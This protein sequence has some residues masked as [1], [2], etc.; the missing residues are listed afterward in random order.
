M[1]NRQ[2]QKQVKLSII[3]LVCCSCCCFLEVFQCISCLEQFPDMAMSPNRTECARCGRDKH[4]PK[5][6]SEANNM[7]PGPV[8][9]Q[10]QVHICVCVYACVHLCV[11]LSVLHLET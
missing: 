2:K 5:L 4:I 11:I 9:P 8:P 10:L 7:N 6:Y 1:I 3:F